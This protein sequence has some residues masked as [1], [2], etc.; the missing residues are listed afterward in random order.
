MT[1]NEPDTKR[2]KISRDSSDHLPGTS[3]EKFAHQNVLGRDVITEVVD[4]TKGTV[5]TTQRKIKI[6][7]GEPVAFISQQ[8]QK[9]PK[10]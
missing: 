4:K 2:T 8:V 6:I 1:K 10:N 3:L 7:D 9:I 5:V